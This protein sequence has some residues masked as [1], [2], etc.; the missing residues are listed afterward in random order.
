M[1]TTLI[2][3]CVMSILTSCNMQNSNLPVAKNEPLIPFVPPVSFNEAAKRADSIVKSMTIEERIDMIGG[4]NF[5]FIN[6]CEK[7]NLP[8]LYLSDATQ[9]VH[10]RKDL[11]AQLEKSVAMP[12]PIMLTSTW[13]RKLAE[14]YAKS[15]GEE[16][17]AG[18][19]AVLLGPG[20]NIYRI[21]QNGRN[22]EY[23]GEDPFLASRM[24]ENYVVGVQST[25]TIAT[26]KH[27]LCNN[28]DHRRRTSNSIVSDRALHEIYLPAFKAGVDAGAMAVMT[29]YNQIN[30]EWAAQS[31]FAVNKLLRTDLGFKWLVM[32]DWWSIWNPE[33]AM[34]SGLD[35]DMP[36]EGDLKWS[37]F[38]KYG[39]SF[40]RS[41]AARLLK[42]GKVGEDDIN[43][44]ATN[45]IATELA[46]QLDKRPIKD[47]SY[48]KN[49][50][51][52][53][54]V[55]LQTAR[56]GIVLLKN[57]N[58]ILPLNKPEMKILVTGYFA[59]ARMSGG[60]SADVEGYDW[61][62][63][64]RGLRNRFGEQVTY[65]QSPT[66]VE[67]KSADVV[68]FSLGTQDSEAWDK[69]FDLPQEMDARVKEIAT[70]NPN[71]VV[72]INSGSGI[73]MSSW[74]DKVAAILH[75]W[76]PGQLGN[77]ALA[78]IL[79]GDVNPSGKLPITIEKKFED[80]PGYPYMP[81]GE[82]HA[83]DWDVDS[84]LNFPIYDI[85]YKEG[86]FVGYRW[87]E[88][89]NIEP[90][91][92]FGYGLS[93][94]TFDYSD[95][96]LSKKELSKGETLKVK[97]VLENT[98]KVAGAEI[99]Q[100]YIQ[101]EQASVERPVKEL[102]DFIKVEL[103][104]GEK[105]L[106]QLKISEEDLSFYDEKTSKWVAEPGKFNVMIGS[107]SKEILLKGSFEFAE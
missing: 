67:I 52:H 73:N 15:V 24:I 47:E 64:V 4:H 91:Y 10:L 70:I 106:V 25:G 3:L 30:G 77:K 41:N 72:V 90:L 21:S 51:Q 61:V 65:N 78:E 34:K 88:S 16:C 48:L 11:D 105:V 85:N 76:Y 2:V 80:S 103:R 28:T 74:N 18:D 62:S 32:S 39:D 12:C 99:A 44:M 46:M 69:S 84:N 71:L 35:L 55:A 58:N 7:A 8:R 20:M 42:E 19:I 75:C 40:L 81:E 59:D 87:Y 31:D 33:K 53:E 13:N 45:I 98:G 107:S 9:G 37:L 38:D 100:L 101:D 93:Y 5:F 26:L 83:T 68:I 54:D 36:G 95:L 60:G 27:F 50:K 92:P 1:R 102:K 22:F 104:P 89:K 96:K 56:E 82:K 79:A 49:F 29:S 17:R 63:I 66:D 6:G 86:V 94:T 14:Q 97:F 23:F 57:S 43:R